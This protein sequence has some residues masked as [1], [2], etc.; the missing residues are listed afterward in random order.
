[1]AKQT[2]LFSN[3]QLVQEGCFVL[4]EEAFLESNDWL[5]CSSMAS[6]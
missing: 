5:T 1:M 2:F 6:K 3:E 4:E